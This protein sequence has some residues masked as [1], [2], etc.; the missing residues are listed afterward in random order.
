M[1]LGIPM[2]VISRNQ[3]QALCER[4]GVQREVALHLLAEEAIHPGDYLIVH[5]GFAI[6]KIRQDD[7]KEA[8]TTWQ[9]WSAYTA[10]NK[11]PASG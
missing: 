4:D 2:K 10:K 11:S 1:C 6:E 9:E 3:Q 8:E 7:A 5:L